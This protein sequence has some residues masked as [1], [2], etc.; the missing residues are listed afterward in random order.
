MPLCVVERQLGISEKCARLIADPRNQEFVTHGI[1]DILRARIH[2]F[3]CGSEDAPS[4]RADPRDRGRAGTTHAGTRIGHDK[5]GR[6]SGE[7]NVDSKWTAVIFPHPRHA[8]QERSAD[9][10]APSSSPSWWPPQRGLRRPSICR[11]R[12]HRARAAIVMPCRPPSRR[13]SASKTT[14]RSP[15]TPW[16]SNGWRGCTLFDLAASPA[17]LPGGINPLYGTVASVPPPSLGLGF[18]LLVATFATGALLQLQFDADET[19]VLE[20]RFGFNRTTHA[21][22]VAD[23]LKGWAITLA[24]SVPLLFACL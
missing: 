5:P 23:Q 9:A 10:C 14:A 24:I 4:G 16:R 19:F 7:P 20:N 13:A 22:F 6:R 11:Y 1:D 21:T 3:A 12:K 17:W 15:T 2:A 8:A 18:A